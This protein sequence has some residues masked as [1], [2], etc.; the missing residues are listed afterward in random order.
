MILKDY[1][2]FENEI[3]NNLL[4]V[5]HFERKP[6]ENINIPD[7]L[8]NSFFI[9]IN[10]GHLVQADMDC[11]TVLCPPKNGFLGLN[12]NVSL[13]LNDKCYSKFT[14]ITLSKNFQDE[15]IE[16][17]NRAIPYPAD[18]I[19][20]SNSY[21]F[22][23]SLNICVIELIE[24]L[25]KTANSKNFSSFYYLEIESNFLR[26]LTTILKVILFDDHRYNKMTA[27]DDSKFLTAIKH[28]IKSK[29]QKEEILPHIDLPIEKYNEL[30]E[31]YFGDINIYDMTAKN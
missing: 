15:I 17:I 28:I 11:N 18:L 5:K 26:L 9:L 27:T 4:S 20:K 12:K 6:S 23:F 14:M 22:S 1:F 21:C 10:I 25:Y 2:N 7:N 29:R 31:K 16:K 24:E 3:A 19:F 8:F 30:Y 13:I